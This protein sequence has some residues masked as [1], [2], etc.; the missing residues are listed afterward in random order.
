MALLERLNRES[1]TEGARWFRLLKDTTI[2]QY[3]GT[4]EGLQKELGWDAN[5]YLPEF[6]GCTHP[7][8][9]K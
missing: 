4:R 3:Y 2:D 8:H 9:Q 1:G 7:E 6:K 5:T